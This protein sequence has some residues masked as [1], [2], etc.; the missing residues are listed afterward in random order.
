[1]GAASAN[2]SGCEPRREILN[3]TAIADILNLVFWVSGT[4]RCKCS[5]SLAYG[6]LFWHSELAGP[7]QAKFQLAVKLTEGCKHHILNQTQ[8]QVSS[9]SIELWYRVHL[10]LVQSG[11]QQAKLRNIR[12]M[13]VVGRAKDDHASRRMGAVMLLLIPHM[14]TLKWGREDVCLGQN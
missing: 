13:K 2:V 8:H 14:V 4:V 3:T 1:M 5:S 10:K 6:L 11:E 7:R 9:I 12:D